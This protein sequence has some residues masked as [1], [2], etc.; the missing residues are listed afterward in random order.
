MPVR[1]PRGQA[2]KI[3]GDTE[4]DRSMRHVLVMLLAA[5]VVRLPAQS[6]SSDVLFGGSAPRLVVHISVD[7]FRADYLTRFRDLYLPATTGDTV[8]GF[9]YLMETGAWFINARFDHIPTG[10]GPGHAIQGTGAAPY[11]NGIVGNSW[12]DRRAGEAVYCCGDD[13]AKIVGGKGGGRSPRYLIAPTYSDQLKRS[14]GGK[15]KVVAVSLKDRVAILTSGHL[16]DVA[17]WY[18]GGTGKLVS[19]DFYCK[20]GKLPA[21]VVEL[22]EAKPVDVYRDRIWEKSLPSEAYERAPPV[23]EQFVSVPESFGTIFPHKLDGTDPDFYG[24]FILTPWSNDFLVDLAERAVDAEELGADLIPD[25][26][27]VG[28]S[29]N[30]YV[31]HVFGPNSPEVLELS[32]AT[33]RALS[34]L[35]NWLNLNVPGGLNRCLIVV[36]A[37]HGLAPLPG[38]SMR[39]GLCGGVVAASELLAA[40]RKALDERFAGSGDWKLRFVGHWLVFDHETAKARGAALEEVERAVADAL[41]L[42]KPVFAAYPRSMFVEGRIPR[43]EVGHAVERSF[44][45]ERCGDVMV[46]MK[47]FWLT[48]GTTG[49]SH[50]QPFLYDEHVPI[51]MRGPGIKPGIHTERVSP[52][53]IA[54]TICAV[55]GV[56]LPGATT[57]D[58]IGIATT[59]D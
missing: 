19:S 35:F 49:T 20:D 17:L 43:H 15:A 27:I 16:S 33:D 3:G 39:D 7:Q 22:N 51:L 34:E 30:D 23:S 12:F 1:S 48:G 56:A 47:P 26:L 21:W 41:S 32:V 46:V 5:V 55:L 38:E 11:V 10:T 28:F 40:A 8:G 59:G 29:T 42:Q 57:G 31:G 14:T 44:R 36:T 37:D 6:P 2:G 45:P 13:D 50:G 4:V 18:D 54:P 24:N 25:V 9:R 58:P 52:E 53:D